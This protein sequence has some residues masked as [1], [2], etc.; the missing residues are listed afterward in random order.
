MSEPCG[1]CDNC[2]AKK[3]REK[4]CSANYEA[5]ILSLLTAE[6]MTVKELVSR[7]V[8]NEK[9]ILDSVRQ[10]LENGKLK[11]ENGKLIFF[12]SLCQL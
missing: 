5:E 10:L 3:K 2:L 7:I 8:G 9:D 1:I 12:V 11:T 6:P 4:S